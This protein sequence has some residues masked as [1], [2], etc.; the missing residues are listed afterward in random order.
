MKQ[1]RSTSRI[2]FSSSSPRLLKP[3]AHLFVTQDTFH[4][5]ECD[6]LSGDQAVLN[7]E[8]DFS[9]NE[10]IS[11]DVWYS[12]DIVRLDHDSVDR[13]FLRDKSH[14]VLPRTHG[15]VHV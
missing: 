10:N 11:S 2:S 4:V 14:R 13:V 8:G 9:P 6:A 7:A 15:F 12:E 1:N 3:R 5:L